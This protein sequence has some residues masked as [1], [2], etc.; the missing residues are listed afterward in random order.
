MNE[1]F[2]NVILPRGEVVRNEVL[3]VVY[4]PVLLDRSRE[5]VHVVA[6]DAVCG[7]INLVESHRL[8]QFFDVEFG[9]VKF[10]DGLVD[11]FQGLWCNL[12]IPRIS[13][14]SSER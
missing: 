11:S 6:Q 7:L 14:A 9:R 12:I 13:A 10:C 5:N 2:G 4:D 1:H 3:V 8:G